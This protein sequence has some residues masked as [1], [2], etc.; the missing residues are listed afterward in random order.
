MTIQL[1]RVQKTPIIV[2]D[3][4]AFFVPAQ[5]GIDIFDELQ[6]LLNR[7]FHAV[8][9]SSTLDE[10]ERIADKGPSEMKRRARYALKLAHKC[11]PLKVSVNTEAP[12]DDIII[13]AASKQKCAVF[14]NDRQL[15]NRLRDINVPVIYVR[16]KSR[17]EIDGRL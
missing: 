6:K 17:L 14:T 13:D 9:L 3:A 2:L 11:R 5:F 16:Q 8:V 12:M 1:K 10:L 4:N 15:R 7:T